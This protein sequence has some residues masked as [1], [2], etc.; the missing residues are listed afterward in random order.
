MVQEQEAEERRLRLEE[1]RL[2]LDRQHEVRM[3]TVFAQMLGMIRQSGGEPVPRP[4]SNSAFPPEA[5]LL[6][7]ASRVQEPEMG[8]MYTCKQYFSPYLSD[9]GNILCGFRGSSEEGYRAYHEDKYDEDKN[10]N[11]SY[12]IS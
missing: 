12:F 6:K 2:Q 5:D 11:V 9:R 3:F 7:R 10:P 8:D 4:P 1:R